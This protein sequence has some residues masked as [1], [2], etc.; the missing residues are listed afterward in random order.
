VYQSDLDPFYVAYESDLDP[1]YAPA[2]EQL[3]DVERDAEIER[4]RQEL[5]ARDD[6]IRELEAELAAL[7]EQRD[8]Y[9][10]DLDPFYTPAPEQLRAIVDVG[11]D[12]RAEN[13]RRAREIAARLLS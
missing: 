8:A 6:T 11:A 1:F 13:A 7:R 3:Q 9:V 10:S 5:A 2:P 12:V 4:L